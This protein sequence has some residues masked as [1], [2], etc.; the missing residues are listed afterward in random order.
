MGVK[1]TSPYST[2]LS[3]NLFTR[4]LVDL[5]TCLLIYLKMNRVRTIL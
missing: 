2:T 3:N 4:L 5:F 1:I